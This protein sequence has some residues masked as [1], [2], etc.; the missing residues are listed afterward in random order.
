MPTLLIVHHTPSPNCQAMFEAV[1]SGATAPEIEGVRVVRR[2]ALSATAGDVLDADGYLLGTP[3][4]LGY[5]SGA[6]KHFFDQVYYPCLDSTKGRPF[7]YYVHGG[8]DVTG[9]VRGIQS[10][11][12]GLGWRSAAETVTVTGE[13]DRAALERCWEL[14]ATIAA[15]LAD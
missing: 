4:N 14:G 10:V 15:G 3:A 9:A 13:P 12:T 1:V 11:T 7:G 2:A 6:L 8:N 5:M